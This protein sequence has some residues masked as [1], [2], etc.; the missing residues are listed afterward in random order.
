MDPFVAQLAHL[1]TAHRTRAKWVFVP[2]HAVGRTLGDRLVLEGT[3]W[4]N[5]RFVTPLDIALLMGA[6]FLVE[7]GIDP[8]EE[9]LGPAL[10]MRLL[11]DL[12][13]KGGYFRPLADQ[14]TL[15]QVLWATVRELRMAGARP[16]DLAPRAF[17]SPAKHAEIVALLSAYERFLDEHRRADMAAVYQE[18]L[19]H[20]DWCPIQSQ[21][22]WTELPDANWNP[23]QRALLDAMPGER[24]TPRT[25][26]LPG[27]SLPR[28]LMSP[29][30]VR[31]TADAAMNPLAFLMAPVASRATDVLMPAIKLF[32]AGGREAEIEEV[33]RCIV[34]VNVSLDQV[35][36]ACASD[37]HLELVWEKALRHNWPVTLGAGIPATFTRP[38][39]ALLGMCDW[40]ETD[41][42]AG[43]FRRL[44]QSGDVHVEE[45][46][47]FT[48]GEAARVLARA[49]AGWGRTTYELALGRL[50][51][52]YESRAIDPDASDADR[53]EAQAKGERAARVRTWMAKR[54]GHIG[55]LAQRHAVELLDVETRKP[56]KESKKPPQDDRANVSPSNTLKLHDSPGYYTATS[57]TCF[58]TAT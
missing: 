37:A 24:L 12:P 8:S 55:Q 21:D 34:S 2:T 5:L 40:I 46:E 52:S 9:E 48:A 31:L 39:R 50:C 44:L 33:F 13:L 15:A 19:T 7:R 57:S 20:P 35:E 28:R 23:L 56:G 54:Y 36:I 18:A 26:T 42:S 47:G 53:V 41:F 49:E 43:H 4:A 10:M 38:G 27:V 22:C 29:R 11:L 3:D 16:G 32:H 6:P 1:C 58:L 14:P 25:F 17:A 45:H 30:T 51:K